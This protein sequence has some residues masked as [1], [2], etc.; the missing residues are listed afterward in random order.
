MCKIWSLLFSNFSVASAQAT[1]NQ[2]ECFP[3]FVQPVNG[4]DAYPVEVEVNEG[5]GDTIIVVM[6]TNTPENF[7]GN[8]YNDLRKR[9][10]Q[11]ARLTNTN[12]GFVSFQGAFRIVH[13]S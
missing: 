11:T 3:R 13:R 12:A 1:H 9:C 4:I 7:M 5:Y 2:P 10:S 8:R 6:A